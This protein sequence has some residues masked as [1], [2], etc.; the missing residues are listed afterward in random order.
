MKFLGRKPVGSLG[1]DLS[2]IGMR[3][4]ERW[5]SFMRLKREN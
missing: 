5:K 4:P 2:V 1:G 3:L